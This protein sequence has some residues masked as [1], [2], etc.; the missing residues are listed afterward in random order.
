MSTKKFLVKG[1]W[2]PFS[3]I[4][5]FWIANANEQV[6]NWT[7][8]EHY[9]VKSSYPLLFHCVAVAYYKT[10]DLNV[11]KWAKNNI[12]RRKYVPKRCISEELV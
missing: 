1:Q 10:A 5:V 8:N 9:T 12:N 2:L 11:Q 7:F 6:N 3:F 4:K